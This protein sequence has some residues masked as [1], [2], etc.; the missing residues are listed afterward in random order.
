MAQQPIWPGSG[1]AVS[2]STPF[3]LYDNDSEFQ[4]EAPKFATWCARR[5]GYPIMS[6]ELQDVQF[7]ACLE[8][9]ITEYSAQVNQFNIVDNLLTLKGQ[10]TGSNFTHKNVTPTLGRQVRLAEQYG[11]EAGVGGSVDIKKGSINVVSGS[12]EYDLNTLFANVGYD[13]DSKGDPWSAAA[14]SNLAQ[15]FDPDFKGSAQHAQY[16]NRAFQG[17][18]NYYPTKLNRRNRK[19]LHVGDILF[20]GRSDGPQNYKDFKNAAK[21]GWNDQNTSAGYKSHSDI[22]VDSYDKGGVTYYTVQGGNVG[23]TI[24]KKDYTA[25]QLEDMYAGRLTQ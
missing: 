21:D 19:D 1:S 24:T 17:E 13:G 18:G 8:E 11:T 2:G 3:G 7:Y 10:P 4:T 22:I 20:K 5:L 12:Q 9:S 25:K 14:V 23:D 15:A 16:I 6:V